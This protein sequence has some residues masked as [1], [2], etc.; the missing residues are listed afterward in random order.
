[1]FN[2]D[3]FMD[4]R[5]LFETATFG[6]ATLEIVSLGS[7]LIEKLHA[8]PTHGN[9]VD[10]V[11][12]HGLAWRGVRIS[13]SSKAEALNVIWGK[14]DMKDA[15]AEIIETVCELSEITGILS[16]KLEAEADEAKELADL[17]A[18]EDKLN[19]DEVDAY[20][21]NHIKKALAENPN[22]SLEQIENDVNAHK[23][24]A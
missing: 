23:N 24:A 18:K 4:N 9:M 15:K 1:M 22:I 13:E 16:D 2:L 6:N 3:E 8:L 14:D 10:F 7:D 21:E 11:A 12:K 20:K 5:G 19:A 17:Q